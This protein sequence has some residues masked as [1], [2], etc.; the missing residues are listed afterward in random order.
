MIHSSII[1]FDPLLTDVLL[2]TTERTCYTINGVLVSIWI[3][4]MLIIEI[5]PI[6]K[7]TIDCGI[8]NFIV[9]LKIIMVFIFFDLN[10][11]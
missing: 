5:S 9:L 2:W 10:W 8:I 4:D 11:P 3:D 1:P 7:A 6:M